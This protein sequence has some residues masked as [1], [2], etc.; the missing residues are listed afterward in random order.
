M[1]NI[2]KVLKSKNIINRRNLIMNKALETLLDFEVSDKVVS[3]FNNNLYFASNDDMQLLIEVNN[4]VI[5]AIDLINGNDKYTI[6]N[7]SKNQ[8]IGID[9][10]CSNSKPFFTTHFCSLKNEIST[11]FYDYTDIITRNKN[12]FDF[13][14][15]RKDK[16]KAISR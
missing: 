13:D 1:N 10:E 6:I 16:V 4:K 5:K 11:K 8:T 3:V 2:I 14:E 12:I 7:N 9:H 15:K